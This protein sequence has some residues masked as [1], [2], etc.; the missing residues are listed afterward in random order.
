MRHRLRRDLQGIAILWRRELIRYRNDGARVISSLVQP[1][2]YLLILGTG[3]STFAQGHLPPGIGFKAFLYPGVIT[4]PVLLTSISAAGSLVWDREFGFLREM[5]VAPVST[6]AI[7]FG[8]CLG[9]AT[10][11]M[12]PGIFVLSLAGF[13]HVPYSPKL[14]A[15]LVGELVLLSLAMSAYGLM[16]A[17]RTK[18]IQ[19]F[20]ALTQMMILPIFFLSGAL[21]PL[22]GM[23]GWL[24]VLTR[25][26]PLTYAVTPLRHAVFSYLSSSTSLA[27]DGVTWAG[28]T[29]PPGL[30]LG[31]VA[32]TGLV[33][34]SLAVVTFYRTE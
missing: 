8:K 13:V 23:P 10:V 18:Q 28:W 31:I 22:S 3:L 15:T 6:G 14:L 1:A 19:T 34:L 12:F 26:D 17:A 33:M 21:Y 24:T 16:I 4:L 7:I 32:A 2:L 30:S 9:G 11:A 29:V 25:V 20:A 27:P 5:L